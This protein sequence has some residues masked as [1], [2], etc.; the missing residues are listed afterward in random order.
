[1]LNRDQI[2]NAL[3]EG[4]EGDHEGLFALRRELRGLSLPALG[5]RYEQATQRDP[6]DLP[7]G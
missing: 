5:K 3:T 7:A 4:K 1:M 2:I 6:H